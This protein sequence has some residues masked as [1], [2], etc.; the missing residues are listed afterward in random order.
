MLRARSITPNLKIQ[1]SLQRLTE[2]ATP[3][4]REDLEHL[5]EQVA[6]N[7]GAPFT[8][9]AVASLAKLKKENRAGFEVLRLR[10][11]E[12]GCRVTSL[13]EAVDDE[14]GG[15]SDRAMKQADMLVA[16]AEE[17]DLFH[18]PDRTGY[19]DLMIEDHRETW[20]IRSKG[21]RHWLARRYYDAEEGA[22]GSAAL[23]AALGVIEAKAN[24]GAPQRVVHLRIGGVE[25]TIYLDLCDEQWRAI[26]I[27]T[28][29]WRVV[30]S[31]PVRF[32]RAPGMQPLPVPVAG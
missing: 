1:T 16:L 28:A 27:S 15:F 6:D 13:D 17:A 25:N 11:K 31:P 24:F 14:T 26:E 18:S 23:Q 22:P 12:A 2:E 3:L 21:F 10:L 5:V 32:R 19:A 29:G 7:P 9:E 4:T 20:P 30:S 8:P